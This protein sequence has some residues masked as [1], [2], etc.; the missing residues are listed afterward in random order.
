MDF[1]RFVEKIKDRNYRRPSGPLGRVI[2]NSM[3]R[4]HEPENLWTVSLLR[5]EPTDRILE[6]GFGPGV[7]TERLAEVAPEGRVCGVDFSTTMVKAARRRNAAAVRDGRVDLRHGDAASLPFEDASFD[8]AFSIH[9]VYFWPEPERVL[10]EARRV[11]RP[12]GLLVLTLLPEERMEEPETT[13]EFR[14]YSGEDLIGMMEK[15]GYSGCRVEQDGDPGLPSNYS[16]LG[17]R[18][19]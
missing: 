12:G 14:P 11:L 10:G 8:K 2:G 13:P 4:Q 18:G 15:A 3:A 5:P 16:V 1:L 6:I 17:R 9:S 7:A 19:A